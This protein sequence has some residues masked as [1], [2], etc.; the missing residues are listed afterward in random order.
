MYND[1]L[2]DP[3]VFF[4]HIMAVIVELRK[5]SIKRIS[6]ISRT[7]GIK[8]ISDTSRTSGIKRI[9]VTLEIKGIKLK[10]YK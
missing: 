1:V 2:V 7:S 5:S 6:G 9:S 4:C 3:Y 10:K 8:R